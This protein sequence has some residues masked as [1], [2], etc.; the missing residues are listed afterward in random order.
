[1]WEHNRPAANQFL[2]FI[3]LSK[4]NY[5]YWNLPLC[6]FC[7]SPSVVLLY[8]FKT[9]I[10]NYQSPQP[11][12]YSKTSKLMSTQNQCLLLP[13]SELQSRLNLVFWVKYSGRFWLRKAEA[14]S[15][16]AP[17]PAS[18]LRHCLQ[19]CCATAC[20]SVAPLPASLFRFFLLTFNQGCGSDLFF[21]EAETL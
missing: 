16:V 17:L 2:K 14:P 8:F 19:V 13:T 11:N 21:A 10:Y 20:K 3:L 4:E 18:L 5:C 9:F 1:M 6:R 7:M 15:V 12:V